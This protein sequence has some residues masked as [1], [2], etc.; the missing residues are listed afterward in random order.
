LFL[1]SAFSFFIS[2]RL[3]ASSYFFR[4]V[5]FIRSRHSNMTIEWQNVPAKRLISFLCI[6]DVPDLNLSPETEYPG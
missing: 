4:F 1:F 5:A 2:F 6:Q 3:L